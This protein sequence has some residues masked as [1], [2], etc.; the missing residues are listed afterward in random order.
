[1]ND[2]PSWNANGCAAQAWQERERVVVRK[3]GLQQVAFFRA[4]FESSLELSELAVRY[5]GTEVSL[6]AAKRTLQAVQD[7]LVQASK[8][9]GKHGAAALLRIPRGRLSSK[10]PA[11]VS[12]ALPGPYRP[13]LDEYRDEVD[14][15]GFYSESELLLMYADEYGP[16]EASP[17]APVD[18]RLLRNARLLE[19]KIRL[20][21]DLAAEIAE[22]PRPEDQID[23][24][25]DPPLAARLTGA[26][27]ATLQDLVRFMNHR[28]YR[29]FALI[30]GLGQKRAAQVVAFFQ[31]S[32]MA[33]ALDGYA[34][35]PTRT[36]RSQRRDGRSLSPAVGAI[37]PLEKFSGP[38]ILDGSQGSNRMPD[39][40]NKLDVRN[41][42]EA[43]HAWL[44]L[45]I[46]KPNT[47]R[48]YRKEAERLLLWAIFSKHKPFS[49]LN[50]QDVADYAHFLA[51]PEPASVWVADRRYDRFHAAWRPFI[52]GGLSSRSIA[53]AV[54]VLA[55]M[56]SWL[57][58][59]RYLDSNPFE[60]LP[61]MDRGSLKPTHR[62]L[63]FQQCG[64]VR[65]YLAALPEGLATTRLRF[66]M[67]LLYATGLRRSE[68]AKACVGDLRLRHF[69]E[70]SAWFLNVIGKG[71][72]EREV[73][74]VR[75]VMNALH[76]YLAARGQRVESV[77][78][79]HAQT[80]LIASLDDSARGLSENAIYLM[81]KSCFQDVSDWAFEHDKEA[82]AVFKRVSTH[83]LRH[84]HATHALRR[85][86]GL[87]SVRDNLGHASIAV[88]SMY[89][90]TAREEQH[91]ETEAFVEGIL[92]S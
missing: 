39:V 9:R 42:L 26:G 69:G 43:I 77:L 24:W 55:G 50:T 30:P 1:M 44:R 76:D 32:D 66:L 61:R 16:D 86:V 48:A 74:F 46:N 80:P 38:A 56:C 37:V 79:L 41:D 49:S 63:S 19:K 58:G 23:G 40:R 54:Q 87:E 90:D 6:P 13:S 91:K 34:T 88:S 25:F 4:A 72:R 12:D 47:E 67:M 65:E 3:L 29:W 83:W 18:R 27:L 20:I 36:Y 28:G 68:V 64:M 78:D 84:T 70:R 75:P 5:L 31:A 10:L 62:S 81:L 22:P 59:Q 89:I 45:Y 35:T 17:S 7:A 51:R 53:Y 21:N 2:V 71:G 14:P 73:P 82:A 85:G 57:V 52:K 8:R 92:S 33:G 60:G 15:G 11:P